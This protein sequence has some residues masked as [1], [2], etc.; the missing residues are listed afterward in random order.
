MT[1]TLLAPARTFAL[2]LDPL[3]ALRSRLRGRLI[4]PDD[5]EYDSARRTLYFAV[6]S[7]PLAI[8]QAADADD[9]A[10]AVT[11]ARIHDLPLAVRSGGHSLAHLSVIDD[12]LVVDLSDMR[13]VSIT[14]E[15]RIAHVQ[16]GATSGD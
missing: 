13:R 2:P 16:P 8:V 3:G 10:E 9:V 7:R 5:A 11:F 6:D 14:P 1:V 12:A 4:T 15:A